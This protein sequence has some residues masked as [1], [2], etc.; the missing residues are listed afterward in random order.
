MQYLSLKD[1][2]MCSY[3]VF[4][5]LELFQAEYFSIDCHQMFGMFDQAV[6]FFFGK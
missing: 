3:M 4:L 6:M 1:A 5:Y 2:G